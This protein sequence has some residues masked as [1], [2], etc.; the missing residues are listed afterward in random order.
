MLVPALAQRY[1]RPRDTIETPLGHPAQGL[2]RKLWKNLA[3]LVALCEGVAD[4]LQPYVAV[5][6]PKACQYWSWKD[7]QKFLHNRERP[8]ITNV[9]DGCMVGMVREDGLLVHKRWRVDTDLPS[10]SAALS[11]VKCS[12]DHQRSSRF[13]LRDTQH[14]PAALCRLALES[15]R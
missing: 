14:Y 11:Q 15:L 4:Y 10:L 3:V 6:W 7:V 9:V 12:Q 5:E 1:A 13:N 2:R 8:I